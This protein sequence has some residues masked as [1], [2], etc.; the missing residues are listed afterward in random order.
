MLTIEK[1]REAKRILNENDVETEDRYMAVYY[2]HHRKR[3]LRKKWNKH[4]R[5]IGY[6]GTDW[7]RFLDYENTAVLSS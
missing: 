2:R 6:V 5:I 3:R 7:K 4:L 1:I